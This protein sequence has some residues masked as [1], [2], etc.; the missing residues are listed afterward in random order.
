MDSSQAS[1]THMSSWRSSVSNSRQQPKM[2]P[3]Y[4]PSGWKI[5]TSSIVKCCWTCTSHISLQHST[6][7]P[8]RMMSLVLLLIFKSPN[9]WSVWVKSQ[10]I[11]NSS[12]MI[13]EHSE[14]SAASLP[15][16]SGWEYLMVMS[17]RVVLI[18][19]KLNKGMCRTY[20]RLQLILTWAL[21]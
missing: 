1:R 18:F 6:K 14:M 11:K 20:W 12:Y 15:W 17:Y 3:D 10:F 7:M 5:S 21:S 4:M 19:H 9:Y 8:L 13:K 16:S 2:K